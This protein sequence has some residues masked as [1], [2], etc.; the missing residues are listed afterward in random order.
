M[1][2]DIFISYRREG[3]SDKAWILKTELTAKGYKVFLDFDEL[4]DGVFN[5]HIM[6]AIESALSVDTFISES[7]S[8]IHNNEIWRF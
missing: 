2:Y 1:K 5:K 4:K 6:Q 8:L 3:G 7:V